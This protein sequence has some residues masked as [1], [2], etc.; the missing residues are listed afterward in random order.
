VQTDAGRLDVSAAAFAEAETLFASCQH[1]T[2]L[3]MV[4]LGRA[5]LAFQQQGSSG[6][7]PLLA[8]LQDPPLV[9]R[10]IQFHVEH[11]ASLLWVQAAIDAGEEVER[12]RAK[13]EAERRRNPSSTEDRL[14]YQALAAFYSRQGD[15]D[16]AESAYRLATEAARQL[17]HQF[18]DPE[19]QTRFR[20]CQEPLLQQFGQ[21]LRQRG[22]ADEAEKLAELLPTPDQ[23]AEEQKKTA[24]RSI[25]A[26]QRA[27]SA[28]T[29]VNLL[30]G[31]PMVAIVILLRE[32]LRVDHSD[33]FLFGIFGGGLLLVFGTVGCVCFL[34]MSLIRFFFPKAQTSKN[35]LLIFGLTPWC[36]VGLVLIFVACVAAA[37]A[38]GSV[39]F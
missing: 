15:L 18:T 22:K 9:T 1:K 19:D 25:I 12:L 8:E 39:R 2:G 34:L 35:I 30:I 5:Q 17:L 14:V 27:G 36:I 29:L 20:I 16:R 23:I 32:S 11:L 26:F 7:V 24:E 33:L 31:L 21:C 28:L 38:V 13:Y 4:A 37:N 10:Q 3:Y 6:L